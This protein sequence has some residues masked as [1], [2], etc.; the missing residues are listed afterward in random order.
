MAA[1]QSG[2]YTKKATWM[3][4]R[5]AFLNLWALGCL[6]L[7]H[8]HI[9][10]I[11]HWLVLFMV[12]MMINLINHLICGLLILFI[13]KPTFGINGQMVC[14]RHCPLLQIYVLFWVFPTWAI[15]LEPSLCRLNAMIRFHV[16]PRKDTVCLAHFMASFQLWSVI[17]SK[18]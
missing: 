6:I 2:G 10:P 1:S 4:I 9:M 14:V 3:R 17:F 11:P 16:G 15:A 7:T 18:T 12:N 13:G 8:I 5:H